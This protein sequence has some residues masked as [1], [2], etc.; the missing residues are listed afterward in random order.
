MLIA[1]PASGGTV[2]LGIEAA[3][4][5]ADDLAEVVLMRCAPAFQFVI[6]LRSSMDGV[7]GDAF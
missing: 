7:I 2:F 5:L 6:R 3:E 1:A 4:M